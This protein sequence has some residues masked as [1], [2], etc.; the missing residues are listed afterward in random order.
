MEEFRGSQNYVASEELLRAANIAMV[1]QK[2]LL[3]DKIFKKY[4]HQN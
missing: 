3:R 4:G 2:P 1:L